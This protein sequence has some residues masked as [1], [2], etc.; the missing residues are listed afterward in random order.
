M[1]EIDALS[2]DFRKYDQ[3]EKSHT[4]RLAERPGDAFDED[5]EIATLDFEPFLK[6]DAADKARFAAQFAGALEEIGFAVL[7]GHGVDVDLYEQMHDAT[8]DVFTSTSLADKM[9]FRAER[10]GS[11]TLTMRKSAVAAAGRTGR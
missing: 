5:Y 9:R 7:V 6:G 1:I 3:V 8:L 11:V 2:R 4:Y 10:Y